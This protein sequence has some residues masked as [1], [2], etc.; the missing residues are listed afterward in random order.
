MQEAYPFPIFSSL[1]VGAGTAVARIP[2][3]RRVAAIIL[4][5]RSPMDGIRRWT[6]GSFKGYLSPPELSTRV[7]SFSLTTLAGLNT[8]A[9][10]GVLDLLISR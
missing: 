4:E 10:A 3:W 1:A 2:R 9:G 6:L 5:P 8:F 7:L